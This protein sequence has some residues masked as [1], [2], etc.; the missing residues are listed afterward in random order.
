MKKEKRAM[1]NERLT[2]SNEQRVKNKKRRAFLTLLF[3][4]CY[5]LFGL[6]LFAVD[7]VL[8]LEQNAIVSGLFDGA[9]F[10][11]Y[12][13]IGTFSVGTVVHRAALQGTHQNRD[14]GE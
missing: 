12:T 8:V 3:V 5:F 7:V 14:D 11:Q 2:I 13:K 6:P 9:R 1:N 10:S 4:I